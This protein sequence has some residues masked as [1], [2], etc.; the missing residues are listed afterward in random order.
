MK[1]PKMGGIG[2]TLAHG[3]NQLGLGNGLILLTVYPSQLNLLPTYLLGVVPLQAFN[4]GFFA[5]ESCSKAK[6]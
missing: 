5:S 2:P 4:F 3:K 6:L 1:N